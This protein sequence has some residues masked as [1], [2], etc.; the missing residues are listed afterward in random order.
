MWKETPSGPAEHELRRAAA[1]VHDER[2]LLDR[3][4]CGHPA[5]RHQRLVVPG[6][7]LRREAVAPLDLAEERF[8]VLGIADGARGD[9]ERP[10]G[11][12][13]LQLAAEVGETVA[14]AR[15]GER[16]EAPPL[17]DTFAEPRDLEPPHDLVYVA[18]ATSATSRRVEFVPRSTAATRVKA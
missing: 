7:Q 18:V 17:V 9:G 4:A 2:V 3:A 1:D 14:N 11:A 13:A 6:E 8:A 16:E 15:D 10:L 12:E 5:K